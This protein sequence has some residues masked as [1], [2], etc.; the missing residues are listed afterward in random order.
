MFARRFNASVAAPVTLP[1]SIPDAEEWRAIRVRARSATRFFGLPWNQRP[2]KGQGGNWSGAGV[3]SSIDFHDHRPYLPGDDPRHINWSAYARSG[4]YTMKLYREEV[5]PRVDLVIDTSASMFWTPAKAER[6]WELLHF[7]VES[8]L[9]TKASLQTFAI[10]GPRPIAWSRENITRGDLTFPTPSTGRGSS[11]DY[12]LAPDLNRIPWRPGGMRILISDLLFPS[13]AENSFSPLTRQCG[14][15]LALIPTDPA[16]AKPTDEGNLEY[17]EVETGAHQQLHVTPSLRHRYQQAY[18]QH[19]QWVSSL[20]R[21]GGINHAFIN[22]SNSLAD[23]L[24]GE[25]L[26]AGVVSA[27]A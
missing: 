25:A 8:A 10:H 2:W 14:I 7:A 27:W 18:Q 22:S 15:A 24:R 4:H 12:P 21:R 11:D 9:L 26:P 23:C 17:Q 19:R 1:T 3:G 13:L 20:L 6:V 5:S 16:E